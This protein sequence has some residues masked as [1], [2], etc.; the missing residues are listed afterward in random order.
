[1]SYS[2]LKKFIL[3]K[4]NAYVQFLDSNFKLHVKKTSMF[5]WI[6]EVV[7][8]IYVLRWGGFTD[9]VEVTLGKF[10]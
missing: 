10:E 5:C 8:I 7:T 2:K 1:M 4:F 9:I 6:A 3:T